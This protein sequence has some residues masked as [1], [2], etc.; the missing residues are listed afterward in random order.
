MR[1]E[2]FKN[3]GSSDNKHHLQTVYQQSYVNKDN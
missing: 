2:H 3:G 1:L